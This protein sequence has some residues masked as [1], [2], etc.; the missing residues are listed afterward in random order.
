MLKTIHN[1][2]IQ[3]MNIPVALL[4]LVLSVAEISAQNAVSY[5]YDVTGNRIRREQSAS[6]T[7][8]RAAQGHGGNASLGV[9]GGLNVS[10]VSGRDGGQIVIEAISQK[11]PH[12]GSAI[13]YNIQ[14][15]AV[16]L[17]D[18]ASPR[19]VMGIGS[20]PSGHYILSVT[21]DGKRH[22]WKVQKH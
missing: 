16:A 2:T 20:L 6:K 18:I 14:G 8:P 1:L 19:T 12:T 15:M 11:T 4:F 22:S 7:A 13:L 9:W 21:T 3:A 17:C 5:V 10:V